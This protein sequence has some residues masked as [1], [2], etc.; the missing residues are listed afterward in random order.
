VRYAPFAGRAPSG[1]S[2][3]ASWPT[4]SSG[5]RPD[6]AARLFALAFDTGEFRLARWAPQK[7]LLVHSESY[8]FCEDRI[9]ADAEDRHRRDFENNVRDGQRRLR[10]D[11][12]SLR[13]FKV[14]AE[15]LRR[16]FT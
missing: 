7:G 5:H 8:E 2:R 1:L 6:G 14:R 10:N 4:S 15:E 11:E 13:R 12:E 9:T 3:R 16:K